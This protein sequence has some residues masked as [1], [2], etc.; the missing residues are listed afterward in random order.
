MRSLL[1]TFPD[2]IIVAVKAVK[3]DVY[4]IK[5]IVKRGPGTGSVNRG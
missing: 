2:S 1:H 5:R 3:E 4:V